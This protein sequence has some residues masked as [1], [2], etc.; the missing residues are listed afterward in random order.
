MIRILRPCGETRGEAALLRRLRGDT[1]DA[2]TALAA[3]CLS[4]AIGLQPLPRALFALLIDFLLLLRALRS[5]KISQ[6]TGFLLAQRAL[7]ALPTAQLLARWRS[8]YGGRGCGVA[9]C[10]RSCCSGI[11]PRIID[12]AWRGLTR[13]RCGPLRR[14][15]LWHSLSLR[16]GP[17][18][19]RGLAL[20]HG[21]ALWHSLPLRCG[22]NLRRSLPLWRG[23][24][25]RR[26]LPLW[27]RGT[28]CGGWMRRRRSLALTLSVFLRIGA[29]RDHQ[30]CDPQHG[31]QLQHFSHDE[32]SPLR[33][34]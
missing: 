26:S 34:Y 24:N 17:V 2:V 32:N 22:L 25:L 9:G 11:G 33:S 23:L 20:R 19:W 5:R 21:L 30:D 1:R 8:R 29:Q 16:C 28:R 7:L 18:L 15:A 10:R 13:W 31:C 14:L 12:N 3:L 6:L 27:R 4:L